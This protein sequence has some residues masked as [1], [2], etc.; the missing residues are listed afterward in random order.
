MPHTRRLP[1]DSA[2]R[3]SGAPLAGPL[4]HSSSASGKK[5]AEAGGRHGA[6]RHTMHAAAAHM[7]GK[8]GRA[9]DLG[10]LSCCQ[11]AMASSGR[12]VPT[13][14]EDDQVVALAPSA[15]GEAHIDGS[16]C[17][18]A[19]G[20]ARR[21]GSKCGSWWRQA[22]ACV[23]TCVPCSEDGA[24]RY[25]KCGAVRRSTWLHCMCK[26]GGHRGR[27]AAPFSHTRSTVPGEERSDASKSW[28]Q[29]GFAT[30]SRL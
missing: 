30:V 9:R 10:M 20:Y 6:I 25:G 18:R 16:Q 27:P 15:C 22:G 28:F 29:R 2:A 1:E 11:P 3:C 23:A 26:L 14:W 7:G 8:V 19:S 4:T 13:E 17:G 5:A 21:D 12:F 24:Q